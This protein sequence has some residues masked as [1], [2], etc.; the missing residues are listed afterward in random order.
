MQHEAFVGD[1]A[2]NALHLGRY[3]LNLGLGFEAWIGMLHAH[4][5][6]QA[7]ENIVA[8]DGNILFLQEGVILG[9]LIDR[10]SQ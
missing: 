1:R 8:G 10:A 9:I 2:Y 4:D 7:F 3:Q 5:S 6:G